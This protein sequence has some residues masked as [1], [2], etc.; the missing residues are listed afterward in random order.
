LS[1]EKSAESLLKDFFFNFVSTSPQ[2]VIKKCFFLTSLVLGTCANMSSLGSP[3][4]DWQKELIE[5]AS[6]GF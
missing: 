5:N 1:W 2:K 3:Q 4:V 6:K